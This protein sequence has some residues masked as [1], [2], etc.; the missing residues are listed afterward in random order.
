MQESERISSLKERNQEK[1]REGG[2]IT[3][4]VTAKVSVLKKEPKRD[5]EVEVLSLPLV[6]SSSFFS[7]SELV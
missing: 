2:K 1:E 3:M 7:R 4:Y 6:L 5:P